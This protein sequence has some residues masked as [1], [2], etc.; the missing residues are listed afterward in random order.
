MTLKADVV[1]DVG[2]EKSFLR[3]G[4]IKVGETIKRKERI[5]VKNPEKVSFGEV[6]STLPGMD[7]KVVE[8]KD[9]D[10]KKVFDLELT[11][12][13]AKTGSLHGKVRVKTNHPKLPTIEL[14]TWANIEGDIG[15][16]P[17]RL[18]LRKSS[19]KDS[20][21]TVILKSQKQ[22]FKLI[23]AEDPDGKLTVTVETI[24]KK[25][26]YA[27]KVALSEAGKKLG[28]NFS[29]RVVITTDRKDQPTFE[30][31]VFFNASVSA[32]KKGPGNLKVKKMP[33]KPLIKTK[34]EAGK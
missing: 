17:K 12:K 16:K 22:P 25:R 5:S 1:V 31:P 27:I 34:P 2:F 4:T 18:T 9:A 29:T 6:T 23:K 21:R 20:S 24:T 33:L 19:N 26:E 3:M 30:L 15:L 11:Y 32:G 14:R 10:G 7:G 13:P 28:K 8:S